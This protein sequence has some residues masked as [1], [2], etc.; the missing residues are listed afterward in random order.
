MSDAAKR[1]SA[2]PSQIL[3]SLGANRRQADPCS[4]VIF[5]GAGDLAKRKLLPAL[6]QLQLD[7]LMPEGVD[8]V[9][10]SREEL[11]DDSYRKLMH[12]AV[13]QSSEI[14]G[15]DEASWAKMAERLHYV[16]GDLTD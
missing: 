5:G 11:D 16:S 1:V 14:T 12:D 2:R 4:I 3:R 7:G 15:F 6:F 13:K 8:I 9:G 10:I